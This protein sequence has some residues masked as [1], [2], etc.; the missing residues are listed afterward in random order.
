MLSGSSSPPDGA[1]SR[2]LLFAKPAPGIS[3]YGVI[4]T[5]EG[6]P[7]PLKLHYRLRITCTGATPGGFHHYTL[8][9]EA[10]YCNNAAP[11]SRAA[12]L[13]ARCGAILYPITVTASP[14]GALGTVADDD[15]ARIACWEAGKPGPGGILHGR[16]RRWRHPGNGTG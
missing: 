11:E 10:V 16:R 15:R 13:A 14:A 7:E 1:P 3:N 8:D 9:R 2:R 6:T 4:L 12:E 5:H